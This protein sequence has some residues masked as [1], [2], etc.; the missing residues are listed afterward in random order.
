LYLREQNHLKKK[1]DDANSKA[2][3]IRAER[4]EMEER[5]NSL[6][7]LSEKQN[8]KYEELYAVKTAKV[9]IPV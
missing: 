4:M 5:F 8:K 6:R 9:S 7:Q 1:L 3:E 2:N